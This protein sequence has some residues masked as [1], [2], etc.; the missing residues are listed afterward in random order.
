MKTL[1]SFLSTVLITLSISGCGGGT[2]MN[3]PSQ[4]SNSP[5]FIGN[6]Y[7]E[8]TSSSVLN[9]TALGGY[10]DTSN[11]NITGKL[12]VIPLPLEAASNSFCYQILDPVPVSG[13]VDSKGNVSITSAAVR[14]QIITATGVL[15]ADNSTFQS[16]LYKVSSESSKLT[17]CAAGD[18]GTIKGNL[19]HPLAGSF[20]GNIAMVNGTH[21]TSL[22]ATATVTQSPLPD[23]LGYFEESGTLSIIG[24]PCF[25]RATM[26]PT[27]IESSI[28]STLV[29]G[30][31]FYAVLTANDNT[32]SQLTVEGQFDPLSKSMELFSYSILGGKCDGTSYSNGLLGIGTL[33][34]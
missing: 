21:V 10:L 12:F 31:S 17:A 22:S 13:T 19:M 34:Q 24:S 7:F 16:G 23:A 3:S 29:L 14:N 28:P 5:A 2:S 18:Q 8:A 27:V 4:T 6:W 20:S 32:S 11:G 33:T 9:S 30:T 26:N 1:I 15:A 25:T